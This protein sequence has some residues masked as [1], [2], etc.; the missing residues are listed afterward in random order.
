GNGIGPIH[1]DLHLTG[2]GA[3]GAIGPHAHRARLPG[4]QIEALR[5]SRIAARPHDVRIDGI[6]SVPSGLAAAGSN[7]VGG[8]NA[9]AAEIIAGAAHRWAVLHLSVHV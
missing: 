1:A 8:R 4:A 2:V 7:P 9:V 6:R 3:H 5:D